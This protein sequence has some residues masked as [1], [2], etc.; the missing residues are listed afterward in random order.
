MRKSG[1]TLQWN[2]LDKALLRLSVS[3]GQTEEL[4]DSLGTMLHRNTVK[5]FDNEESP[6]GKKWKKSRRALEENG[7]TLSDTGNLK[8][9]ISY[10]VKG[11]SV[12]VGTNVHY[13]RIHQFGGIIKPKTKKTLAFGRGGKKILA[14]QVIMPARPF[15]GISKEDKDEARHI[16]GEFLK[17]S[18]RG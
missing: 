18:F 15:I 7:Q 5:R 16:I 8:N 4:M 12:M 1:V 3:L 9:N 14:K 10:A 17:E 13:A 2:N 11:K 6:S